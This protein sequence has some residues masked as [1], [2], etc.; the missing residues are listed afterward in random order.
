MYE[1]REH[2]KPRSSRGHRERRA[3]W[4]SPLY[5]GRQDH[6]SVLVFN[7]LF[8]VT[9]WYITIPNLCFYTS[10][11]CALFVRVPTRPLSHLTSR[12]RDGSHLG[13]G[14]SIVLA[15][16]LTPSIVPRNCDQYGLIYHRSLRES[17]NSSEWMVNPILLS[18]VQAMTTSIS[19]PWKNSDAR[20]AFLAV[21]CRA[22]MNRLHSVAA[23]PGMSQRLILICSL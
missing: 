1:E 21:S 19:T 10:S 8:I 5:V 18:I 17:Q 2:R 15:H 3:R 20:S 7:S 16:T 6:F 14:P 22:W 23:C 9:A 4:I 11:T 12:S 13:Q